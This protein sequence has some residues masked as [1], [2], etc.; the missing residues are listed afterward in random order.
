MPEYCSWRRAFLYSAL[1]HLVAAICLGLAFSGYMIQ[2][3]EAEYVIDLMAVDYLQ[4]SGHEGGG[5]AQ[6]ESPSLSA[7]Q[8]PRPEQA[9]GSPENIAVP[10]SAPMSGSS[11]A[12]AGSSA[13]GTGSG[14]GAGTGTGDGRGYGEG[15]GSGEGSGSSGVRGKGSGAF[16]FDGFAN[17]VDAHKQYPYMAVKRNLQGTVTVAVTLD[18]NGN[19]VSASTVGSAASMLEQ[20]ALQA[21][22]A[23]CP[24]PN[25]LRAP[26]SFTT[27]VHFVLN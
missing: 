4:G 16:D 23:V 9:A 2:R 20:A 6:N 7:E 27:T 10:A 8:D 14:A 22:R 12:G 3:P 21:I 25:A 18:A 15:R 24:Y 26:V 5:M 19:L 1:F 11:A 17:A 13:Y